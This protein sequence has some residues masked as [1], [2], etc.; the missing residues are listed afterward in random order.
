MKNNLAAS[1]NQPWFG[2]KFERILLSACVLLALPVAGFAQDTTSS[3]RGKIYNESGAVVSGADVVV[4][5]M[6][7]GARRVITSNSSGSF[8]ASNLPVGGPYKVTVGGTKEVV[9]DSIGLGDAYN[10]TIN[11]Q[12]G[13]TV[14]E[15]V[16]LGQAGQIVDVAAGPAATFN[17]YD[18]DTA[19][20]FDRDITNVYSIDPRLNL[21]VDGFS[22]NCAGQH[23]RFNSVTMD[24]VSQNDRFGLNSNGYSTATGMPFPYGGIEQISVELAPF[25]VTY[26]GFSAC[27]I[28]VVSKSGSN[29]WSGGVFYEYTSDDYRGD[30]IG[31]ISNTF[32]SPPYTEEKIGFQF[33]GPIIQDKL[34]VYAAYE[35]T[36]EPRFL[37]HGY[38][39]SGNG[40]ERPWL[41]QSDYQRIVDIAQNV[42]NYDTGGQ[43]QDGV[44]ENESYMVRLDWNISDRHNAAVIYN[45]FDGFQDRSSDSD[46][47][48]FEFANHFY[49]KGAVSE[50]TTVKLS[51]QWTDAFSTEL[52]YSMNSMDDS[53]VTVGPKDFADMQISIGGRTG[54]VYLGADDS[55][56]ANALNTDSDFLK[57]GGQY[58]AGDHV[59]SFGY[60]REELTIFNQFVQHARGGEYDYFDDSSDN[61]AACAALTAQE[62]V[63]GVLGCEASG[64]DRFE[65]GR[66][67]RIYYGSGGGTNNPDDAA[68]SF[69]NTL[70]SFYIQD[71]IFFDE[72]DLTVIAGF[73]YE[74]FSS[75]D[76]P[77]FNP[78]FAAAYGGLRNDA[79]IDGVDLVMPRLGF[80]WNVSDEL[81]LRGGVGLFSGGNP[82]V[83]ISNAWSNDGIS[84]VQLQN[85][86]F[87]SATVLPGMADSLPLIGAGRPGFDV[88]QEMFDEVAGT[89]PAS[90]A[91]S[92][93]ALIDPDYEQPSQWKFA[94][95]GTYELPFGDMTADIDVMYSRF[96]DAAYYVDISQ[97]VVGQTAAGQPIYDYAAGL[98]DHNFML[99][100]S[101][102]TAVLKSFAFSL[103]KSFDWG[104]DLRGGYAYTDAED[105]SPMVGSTAGTN[106]DGMA[107]NDIMNPRAATSDYVVPHRFTLRATYETELFSDYRTGVTLF[108]FY[109]EGQPQ[110]YVMSSDEQEGDQRDGRHLLYVPTG[111]GDPNVEFDPGFDQAAFFAFVAAEGLSPGFQARNAQHARWSTRFDLR[112]DQE[113]PTFLNDLRGKLFVKIYNLGNLLNDDW[114]KQWDAQPRP[115]DL[116]GSSINGAGQYV[117]ES[118]NP[119]NINDLDEFRS[120]WEARIGIEFNFR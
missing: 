47:N 94:L 88:P 11:M 79:S 90:A 108:G 69:A 10:L 93:L 35:Q 2:R 42:Y 92:N 78:A 4:E 65:L 60:E 114:G 50:T 87:D 6:R 116:V 8:F 40:I 55:R 96:S 45:Y 74:R 120:L 12:S 115:I 25:D 13:S 101:S 75:D 72:H 80:T 53:Q 24:G 76:S 43:G 28:N 71:E 41:S 22:V 83:W 9:V 14:E 27:N 66:P 119:D 118:Y 7:T 15:I 113:L 44:Q 98:G 70:H 52:F 38:A 103:S 31:G 85:N 86:Y 30:K 111:A 20:A 17:S 110:S 82:N 102:E 58:L 54:V 67:S 16:V 81:S 34:F 63:D 59:I 89:T 84:N 1:S 21:D 64:I 3:I 33:G 109:Q 39:G 18:I 37:S 57:L 19:V 112:L 117:F 56:Q 26:G 106:F 51:S 97:E 61:D 99:T 46:P 107:L 104:L 77:T 32:S 62:R 68:A 48:E 95:G 73:R 49:R 91:N 36:E 105:V 23:P 29:E 5:D 100:N